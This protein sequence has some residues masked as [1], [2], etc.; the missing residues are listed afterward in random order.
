MW[1]DHIIFMI[2]TC[3][4]LKSP[5]NISIE[6]LCVIY[7]L[8]ISFWLG[9]KLKI[10]MAVSLIRKAWKWNVSINFYTMHWVEVYVYENKGSLSSICPLCKTHQVVVTRHFG[11]NWTHS[12]NR[13]TD[14]LS[15]FTLICTCL[16]ING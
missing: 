15:F 10:S 8:T 9:S 11:R 13:T 2:F 7:L 14:I 5:L 1:L 12:S 6:Q 4:Q 3:H 16:K